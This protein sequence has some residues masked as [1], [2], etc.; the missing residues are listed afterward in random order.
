MKYLITGGCGFLG[1]NL[2]EE[3][4][5]KGDELVVVDN[6]F[7]S[8]TNRNLE[9]LKSIGNFQYYDVNI[10]NYD[11]ISAIFEKEKPDVVFHV[12]GQVAMTTSL[13][14]PRLD[15][16]INILGTHNVLE[17]V[18]AHSPDA[19]VVY[20]S[21]NKVYGDLED[22]NYK[23]EDK[24]YSIP[25]YP[26]GLPETMPLDFS[27]P[28]GCSKGAADQYM[29]DYYRSFGIKTIVFRH[30][31][32]FGGRQFSTFD[33]GWIGWFVSRG[34]E[35]KKGTLTEP[36][37]I[38]GSGKQVRDVLFSED[39]VSCYFKA[40]E[41]IEKTKGQVFNIG[42]GAK[43][44]LSIL[45][46]FEIL[47]EELDVKLNYTKLAPRSSDQKNFIADIGKAKEYFGWNPKIDKLS[48]IKKMINW[49]ETI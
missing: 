37:T 23:E 3:V 43:N 26:N 32:I 47:E 33:Q 40:I 28:Y 18:R 24:R 30:S 36:F 7:R 8:G 29:M 13:E 19:I 2:A 1:S 46:L 35:S 41:N 27:T 25:K 44:S 15:L 17:S 21:T 6:L 45:E 5:K 11:L 48:G 38:S 39:I 4:I 10:T 42:G 34:I 20:S 22:L 12:A 16:E 49:V 14:K 9:W 31:S